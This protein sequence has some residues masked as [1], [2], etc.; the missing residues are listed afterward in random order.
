MS[1]SPPF[2]SPTDAKWL[3]FKAKMQ[4]MIAGVDANGAADPNGK[5]FLF[6]VAA[7]NNSPA[8][9]K[10]MRGQCS[11]KNDAGRSKASCRVPLTRVAS[12]AH[13]TRA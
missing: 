7:G 12:L 13:S 5:H 11:L 4:G 6:V 2:E 10:T 1:S 9:M 8:P 3:A